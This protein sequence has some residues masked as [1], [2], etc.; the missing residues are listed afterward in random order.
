MLTSSQQQ[1]LRDVR[2]LFYS[3]SLREHFEQQN[4]YVDCPGCPE[5][6][7]PDAH[8]HLRMPDGAVV[9]LTDSL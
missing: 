3:G 1:A 9:A 7:I 6:A 8:M 4:I 2:N 5:C